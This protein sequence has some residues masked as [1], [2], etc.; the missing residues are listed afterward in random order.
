[1]PPREA[2]PEIL[3]NLV[4]IG[5]RGCGKSSIAKR[6]ARRNRH[7]MLFS[8][9]ALI[10]YEAGGLS[11]PEIV[12]RDGWRGFREREGE[13]VDKVAAFEREALLDCGGGVVVDLDGRG[14]EIY[15]ERKIAALRRHGLVVYL[16]RDPEYLLERIGR[17]PNRPVLSESRSFLELMDRRD[18]WYR[19]AADLTLECG[20]QS[21]SDLTERVLD[22]FY[23]NQ[24]PREGTT[25]WKEASA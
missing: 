24:S 13:V 22:W 7:F 9:D 15:G 1:M 2:H 19:A 16:R 5:G 12:E 3:C 25:S 10:R 18:P 8:L 4:L 23:E 11:I 20:T 21:K 17:D 6:I 14:E